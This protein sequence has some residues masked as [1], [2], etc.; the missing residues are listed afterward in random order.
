MNRWTVTIDPR[1]DARRILMM[2]GGEERLRA[3]LGPSALAHPRAASTLLEG[4]A[5]WQRS[6]CFL[7]FRRRVLAERSRT[8]IRGRRRGRTA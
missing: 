4:L 2:E 7:H 5:L 6:I 3:V 1:R 8:G